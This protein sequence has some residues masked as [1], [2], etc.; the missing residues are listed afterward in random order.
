MDE[1]SVLGVT[2]D[3]K[4]TTSLPLDGWESVARKTWHKWRPSLVAKA[5]PRK[6]RIGNLYAIAGAALL[7]G[8]GGWA[9]HL[10]VAQVGQD[11]EPASADV[12]GPE[13]GRP[14][15]VAGLDPQGN[16]PGGCSVRLVEDPH[17]VGESVPQCVWT[18][19]PF[20]SCPPSE[21]L[22]AD[23][24]RRRRSSGG[25]WSRLWLSFWARVVGGGRGSGC[26]GT[27]RERFGVSQSTWRWRPMGRLHRFRPAE[28]GAGR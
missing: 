15:T 12:G 4:G 22:A 13:E 7:C 26:M 17:F 19:R 25:V 21:S 8:S 16:A 24:T 6:Q 20:C 3:R 28:R 27:R 11:R 5:I 18:A 1:N 14:R 2:V 23:I 9:V 10:R